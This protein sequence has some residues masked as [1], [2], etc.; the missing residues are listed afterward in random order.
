[1][2]TNQ[3]YRDTKIDYPDAKHDDSHQ[4]GLAF[5]DFVT[6]QLAKRGIYLQNFSSKK[7]QF[8]YGENLQRAEIKLD[9]RCTDTGRLSIEIAEKTSKDQGGWI[10]SGIYRND[11]WIYIQGN[12]QVL[13][14]FFTHFLR[15][16]HEA[17]FKDVHVKETIKTFYLPL[18]QAEKYGLK[19]E[20][21]KLSD[22]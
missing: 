14:I 13:F 10:P 1:M 3:N 9:D 11:N 7:F 6:L 5:Q 22:D 17:K 19:I 2:A 20:L 4:V 8:A 16:L 15:Q 21:G 18:D 12:Q